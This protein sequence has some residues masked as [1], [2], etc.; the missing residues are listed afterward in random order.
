[1][2]LVLYIVYQHEHKPPT[3]LFASNGVSGF[4]WGGKTL[5]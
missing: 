4:L 1:M 2:A 5:T 3:P